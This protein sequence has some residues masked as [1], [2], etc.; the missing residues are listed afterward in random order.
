MTLADIPISKTKIGVP[1]RKADLLTRE[2]LLNEIRKY[3]DRRLITVSAPA[4]YG[5]T[6][7]LVDLAYH[8]ELPFCWLALDPLDRDPQR[9][10]AYFI[11]AIAERFPSIENGFNSALNASANLQE[12]MESVLVELTNKIQNKI[13]EPFVLVLDDFDL[14]SD[15][16]PIA[17]FVNRFIYLANEH[18]HLIILSRALPDLPDIT[19][20]MARNQMGRLSFFDLSFQSE[21]LKALLASSQ[22]YLSEEN[23]ESL[24]ETTEGWIAA[25]QFTD[26]N[27]TIP[28]PQLTT[29]NTDLYEYFRRQA[30]EN[31]S[32][33]LQLFLLRSSLLEEFDAEICEKVLGPFYSVPQ[34]WPKL[35]DQIARKNL[36]AL[37]VSANG[38]RLRY[39]HLF[40]D[41]LSI[42]F[43]KEY[44]DEIQPLLQRLAQ[45]YEAHGNE[46]K[47]YQIYRQLGDLDALANLIRQAGAP[48]YQRTLTTLDSWI[49][50]V[51]P[52]LPQ[53]KAGLLS[54]RG[55]V[56]VAAADSSKGMHS[57]DNAIKIFRESA[58]IVNLASTLVRRGNAQLSMGNY[59]EA[60][61]DADEAM[62]T[63]GINEELQW[64]Y[65][66]AL[67]TKG[68]GLFRQGSSPEG[69]HCLERAL[70]IYIRIN[71]TPAISA[72]LAETGMIYT[73]TGQY[74]S[75]QKA[76]QKALE[77][78]RQTGNLTKQADLLNSFGVLFQRQGDYE[79]AAQMLEESL[80]YARNKNYKHGEALALASL[81][82][83]YAELEDFETA[84]RNYKEAKG[85]AQ[86]TNPRFL[87]SYLALA[88]F[89]LAL[90]KRDRK[91]AAL[92]SGQCAGLLEA[93][94]SNYESSLY[95]LLCAKLLLLDSK[96]QQ[97]V[98]ELTKAKQYFTEDSRY[99]ERI[100]SQV[101]MAAAQH[102]SGEQ[103]AA[104]EEMK[105]L[106]KELT[107]QTNQT[108][109]QFLPSIRREIG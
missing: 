14:V 10:I 87:V 105:N 17:Y 66:D 67:R 28:L 72:L 68:L 106:L 29:T 94:R 97:A 99:A 47:A 75:A 49:K 2:R 46:E 104:R 3:L 109:L 19:L 76:H 56:A 59:A 44:P 43:R 80:L 54:L 62:E 30:L 100:S 60:V 40:R 32:E 103:T 57:F 1:K 37:P 73:E 95:Q 78:W 34:D 48:M 53:E 88:E 41:F 31:Q 93:G 63:V 22:I 24:F 15:V 96:P 12:G 21:E 91:Q 7:L 42:V 98:E 83:L 92:L 71:N 101:W 39:H 20:F 18:C 84:E 102:K 33:E 4:G 27:S 51:P 38:Q 69:I 74:S 50:K 45:F 35:M 79:H 55:L 8:N 108:T 90:L 52:S 77:I 86:Q 23:A 81:G 11:A 26:L 61:H 25:L 58:D 89:N 9:F 64:I 85:Q 82:D 36:F 6:S 16:K 70:E 5:K 107:N 13:G 65:A